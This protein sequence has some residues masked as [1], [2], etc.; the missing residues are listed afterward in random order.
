MVLR[1]GRTLCWSEFGDSRGEVLFLLHG[2]PG[3]RL[4]GS[5][6][7]TQASSLG[8]RLVCPDRPGVGGS[9]YL[10]GRRLADWPADLGALAARLDV[11]RFMLA[12]K[13]AGGPYALACCAALGSRI[14]V[15][16]LIAPAA[17]L[18]RPGSL[19]G[20]RQPN[21]MLFALARRSSLGCRAFVTLTGIALRRDPSPL[22]RGLPRPLAEKVRA[23]ASEGYRDPH[24]QLLELE[25]IVQPWGIDLRSIHVPV[26]LWQGRNDGNIG[27]RVGLQLA[28]ALPNCRA[29]FPQG[30]GDDHYWAER[31]PDRV[32]TALL[33]TRS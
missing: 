19:E 14:S 1:D 18:N 29:E 33:A 12:G 26:L 21:R 13:S 24:G 23:E 7:D 8:I 11:D 17:E 30:D 15:C 32:L 25:L 6:F 9:S 27:D 22:F 2:W 3:S 28:E 20:V 5:H 31:H 16:G 4:I 10:Q